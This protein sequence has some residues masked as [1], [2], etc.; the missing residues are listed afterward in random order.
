[1]K[2][3]D[4]AVSVTLSLCLSLPAVDSQKGK[5]CRGDGYLWM[6]PMVVMV[7]K[8]VVVRSILAMASYYKRRF[9]SRLHMM[10]PTITREE[11][12]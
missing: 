12:L 10:T 8:L 5:L 7:M 4:V 1:M 11:E 9:A 2:E 3:R 6:I